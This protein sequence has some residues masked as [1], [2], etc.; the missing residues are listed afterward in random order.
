MTAVTDRF[1]ALP[2]AAVSDAL[3]A[4]GLSGGAA[5]H[6][7]VGKY[8]ARDGSSVHSA[9]RADQRPGRHGWGLPG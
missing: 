1:A 5:R 6:R 2:T 4:L 8:R 9:I 3:D 7:S